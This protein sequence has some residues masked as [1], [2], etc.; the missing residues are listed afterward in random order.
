[1]IERA[2]PEGQPVG[3]RSVGSVP[4]VLTAPVR[5]ATLANMR[6]SIR[7]AV[8]IGS[9]VAC[10]HAA[11]APSDSSGEL[12]GIWAGTC[13]DDGK[14]SH[15]RG[16]VCVRGAGEAREVSIW[17]GE[18]RLLRRPNSSDVTKGNERTLEVVINHWDEKTRT[19]SFDRNRIRWDP[20]RNER[21]AVVHRVQWL[22]L[23]TADRMEEEA[24]E[25]TI[26][27]DQRKETSFV[28]KLTRVQR[29]VERS[30]ANACPP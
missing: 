20:R 22:R 19:F 10:A 30:G 16:E 2:H 3:S 15:V 6:G 27:G 18:Y 28:C 8:W 17:G 11:A 9:L 4:R 13:S 14:I 5:H 25:L 1:V 7:Q 23:V 24:R 12:E 21:S 29:A 26:Q